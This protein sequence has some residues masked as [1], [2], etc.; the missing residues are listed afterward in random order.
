MIEQVFNYENSTVKVMTDFFE[1]R[2]ENLKPREDKTNSSASSNKK[3][4]KKRKASTKGNEMTL[5]PGL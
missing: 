3:K 4:E 2:V 5:T 1:T